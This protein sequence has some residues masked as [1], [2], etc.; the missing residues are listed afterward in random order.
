MCVA[1]IARRYRMLRV[2]ESR[3]FRLFRCLPILG[4]ISFFCLA[5]SA[6]HRVSPNEDGPSPEVSGTRRSSS[7]LGEANGFYRKGDFGKAIAKFKEVL[8]EK[9][10]SPDGWA[11]L[12]RSY[13][14]DK[15]VRAAAESAQQAL[16]AVDHPRV[17]TARAEVLFRQGEIRQAEQEWV[18]VINS[19]YPEAR[20]YLG[21]ARVR[22]ANSMYTSAAKL[23]VKAHEFNPD[24]SDIKHKIRNTNYSKWLGREELFERERESDPDLSVWDHCVSAC[25]ELDYAKL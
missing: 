22:K 5:Q 6:S 1:G 11:G 19:G 12:I 14:K 9:P 10:T 23:I 13:L 7:L 2:L 20:A 16:A 4:V 21:L 17:R 15:N 24:D 25:A 8:Q 3:L 18:D